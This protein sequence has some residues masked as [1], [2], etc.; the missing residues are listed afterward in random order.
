MSGN[1]EKLVEK[2]IGAAYVV[3]NNQF[4]AA[5]LYEGN[6][7]KILEGNIIKTIPANSTEYERVKERYEECI[8]N[9]TKIECAYEINKRANHSFSIPEV[10]ADPEAAEKEWYIRKHPQVILVPEPVKK[11][12]GLFGFF[13]RK[14]KEEIGIKCLKCG[15]VNA[16]SQKFCG[17]CG[18][19]LPPLD[20]EIKEGA[21][22][23]ADRSDS[24]TD[25][26]SMEKKLSAEN[27][28]TKE[29]SVI[30]DT[31]T[32]NNGKESSVSAEE[33]VDF[34]IADMKIEKSEDGNMQQEISEKKPV[35]MHSEDLSQGISDRKGKKVKRPLG[36]RL[37]L[38]I[39]AILGVL[40]LVCAAAVIYI[41][42]SNRG[43]DDQY[44]YEKYESYYKET[45]DHIVE[46]PVDITEDHVVIRLKKAI[47]MNQ[48]ISEE[49]IEG[50]ILSADQYEKYAG[51]STY[52]DSNGQVRDEKL[53]L[54]EDREDVIGKYAA[55]DLAE[56]SILYDTSVTTEHVIV[57]KT[58]VDVEVD[59]EGNTIEVDSSVLPG[60]THIQIVAIIQTDGGEPQQVLLS[61]MMLQDRSL[62]SIFDAAGQNI[63]EKISE[64]QQDAEEPDAQTDDGTEAGEE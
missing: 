43:S 5:D 22:A 37:L 63:L 64:Q 58:F 60:N 35:D 42:A 49:E 28:D 25:I 21:S 3:Y 48:Q 1:G 7:Y 18:E 17:E 46:E 6:Y 2:I 54:W 44:D 56:G 55:R 40:M 26:G 11:K 19:K 27:E 12:K 50:V 4:F 62:Q 33:P 39:A 51:I 36:R 59:G 41:L 38:I 52:I 23:A 47:G 13:K 34:T 8:R 16:K 31:D 20:D 32:K 9:D 30:Q 61:E 45:D 14:N 53:L 29:A 10:T 24:E 57:D 15:T